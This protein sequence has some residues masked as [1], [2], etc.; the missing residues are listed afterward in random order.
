M[1]GPEGP[2]EHVDFAEWMGFREG[3]LPTTDGHLRVSGSRHR[4]LI[5]VR[6]PNY[7]VG[8]VHNH[9]LES[10]L[11]MKYIIVCVCPNGPL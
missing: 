3:G 2:P 10:E 11:Q 5:Y 9:H 4:P 8:V 1:R 7:D 6:R